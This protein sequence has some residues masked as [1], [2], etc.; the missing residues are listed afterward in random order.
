VQTLHQP[1]HRIAK[2]DFQAFAAILD[3]VAGGKQQG[4]ERTSASRS[5]AVAI[6]AMPR[7]CCNTG[8]PVPCLLPLALP[9][10]RR[11]WPQLRAA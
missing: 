6:S 3:M 2:A 7:A 10:V 11:D 4:G 9:H 8:S 1:R 5:S